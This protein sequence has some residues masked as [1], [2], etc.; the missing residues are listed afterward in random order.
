ML[1]IA[2]PALAQETIN[3]P[4]A[5]ERRV[6][7]F[8]KIAVSGPIDLVFS[9]GADTKVVVSAT[10]EKD[11]K[12]IETVVENDVLKIRFRNR[13]DLIRKD[14]RGNKFRA[15]V[16]APRL[17]SLHN[18]G[19]GHTTIRGVLKGDELDLAMSGS[20]KLDG[21]VEV[22]RLETS[23]LGSGNIDLKGKAERA[24]MRVSGSGSIHAYELTTEF[25]EAAISG[26][27]GVQVTT[28]REISGR[29]SGSGNIR[30]RGEAKTTDIRTNGSGRLT[31][32]DSK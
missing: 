11:L 25:C 20:G 12:D 8:T 23:L 9:Q 21:R 31:R 28:M 15:Y 26:S 10:N 6:A 13:K 27:G 5:Q 4:N 17:E 30:Y 19:S 14:W 16:S 2:A 24:D 7:G 32:V 18:G 1:M 22:T 29:I 3:E